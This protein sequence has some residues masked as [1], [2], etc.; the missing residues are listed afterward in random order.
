M[1]KRKN[2]NF[3]IVTFADEAR[4]LDKKYKDRDLDS[5]KKESFNYEMAKL[6]AK[7]E[8]MKTQYQNTEKMRQIVQQ[9]N[10]NLRA[11]GVMADGGNL[12]KYYIGSYLA[13][14][15]FPDPIAAI[16]GLNLV[17]GSVGFNN[18]NVSPD[19][20]SKQP[21]LF[22]QNNESLLT[23]TEP[24]NPFQ[25]GPTLDKQNKLSDLTTALPNSAKLANVPNQPFGPLSSKENSP[26]DLTT[27]FS[28]LNDAGIAD[29]ERQAY[30][31]K[32][33][34]EDSITSP[35]S[36]TSFN[37]NRVAMALKSGQL[38]NSLKNAV[39]PALQET[40][41]IPDFSQSDA[42]INQMSYDPTNAL[43]AVT[44]A[45]NA[46]IGQINE[47][48][49]SDAV[50][51]ARLAGNAAAMNTQV[52]N[53]EAQSNLLKN[54]ILGQQGQYEGNKAATIASAFAQNR[55]NNLQNMAAKKMADQGF[56][57]D[58]S[59]IGTEFNKY[60]YLQDAMKNQKD[61]QLLKNTE[62]FNYLNSLSS[63]FKV[64][65]E[66]I[67]AANNLVMNPG[68]P[69][70]VENFR[71]VS[72]L[73]GISPEAQQ[74]AIDKAKKEEQKKSSTTMTNTNNSIPLVT[75]TSPQNISVNSNVTSITNSA[76]PVIPVANTSVVNTP[77]VKPAPV[78]NVATPNTSVSVDTPKVDQSKPVGTGDIVVP[79]P[80]TTQ[81]TNQVV[82]P[83]T[84]NEVKPQ[85]NSVTQPTTVN[86]SK[87]T[88]NEIPNLPVNEELTVPA[89]TWLASNLDEYVKVLETKKGELK[90]LE[91]KNPNSLTKEQ[92]EFKKSLKKELEQK[93]PLIKNAQEVRKINNAD[94]NF[95]KAILDLNKDLFNNEDFADVKDYY[96]GLLE[97]TNY[98][99][100]DYLVEKKDLNSHKESTKKVIEALKNGLLQYK[101]DGVDIKIPEFD[102]SIF[103]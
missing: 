3:N 58:L 24:I 34:S 76:A 102:M 33:F 68:D 7:N 28:N 22:Q 40:P 86:E 91:D 93:E 69:S 19:I 23:P 45:N 49:M 83:V 37:Y 84:Q 95:R 50:R 5:I 14:G 61:I 64:T 101:K 96:N 30:N 35:T 32:K 25:G 15:G 27:A 21:K 43:N 60:Q 18:L 57:E 10:S 11:K 77:A 31:L 79:M 6:R 41:I 26:M 71:K 90:K 92:L 47:S 38:I 13:P 87:P 39:T 42:R 56:V 55:L 53:I 51:Q 8:M 52:A 59:K 99:S 66:A 88:G 36:K 78:T 75:T 89:N 98:K 20:L 16:D 81:T 74:E 67:E 100:E 17:A 73:V 4:A 9:G 97:D 48:T 2:E 94:L 12:P 62:V 103:N 80:S 65:P 46:Q 1:A 85:T 63:T 44:R 29:R 70:A 54:Q 82:T 72:T